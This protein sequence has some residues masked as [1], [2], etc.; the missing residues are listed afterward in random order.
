[1]QYPSYGPIQSPYPVYPY[2]QIQMPYMERTQQYPQ[3]TQQGALQQ[4]PIKAPLNGRIVDSTDNIVAS[5]V[6]MDGSFA[7]FPRKDLSSIDV[8]YWTNEGKIATVIFKPAVEQQLDP[9]GSQSTFDRLNDL[10]TI[11]ND[12]SS[13]I[14]N[15]YC[16]IDD[17]LR[18][19]QSPKTKKEAQIDE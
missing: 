18:P 11:V 10:S 5:D 9:Q 13:K 7:V 16:R 8:K 15:L 12:L 14:D 6:P 4:Q 2:P 19:K 3:Q 1:M 17:A